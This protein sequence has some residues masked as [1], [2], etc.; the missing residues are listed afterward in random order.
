MSELLASPFGCLSFSERSKSA[1]ELMAPQDD[2]DDI[3]RNFLSTAVVTDDDFAD[4]ASR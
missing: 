4:F 1:A 2:D 3:R